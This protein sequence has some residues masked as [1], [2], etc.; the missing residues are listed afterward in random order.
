MCFTRNTMKEKHKISYYPNKNKKTET[1]LDGDVSVTKHYHNARDAYVKELINLKDGV[2]EVKHFTLEGVLS[3]LEYFVED[4]RHGIE[5]KYSVPKANKTVKS[6]KTYHN[7]KLHGECIT[8]NDNN[9]IIK[10]EVFALGKLVLKYLRKDSN[11]ITSIEIIDQDNVKNLAK[12]EY[13]K[14]Q[15]N[16]ENNPNLF[17]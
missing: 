2:K 14:L 15:K 6:T 8:Y 9:E 17:M 7:G 4:K 13:E 5:T 16:I 11:D 12:S 1:Y 3:K 10:Q